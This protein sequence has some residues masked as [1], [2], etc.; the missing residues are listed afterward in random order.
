[1]GYITR[2][3]NKNATKRHASEIRSTQYLT[4]GPLVN[5]TNEFFNF[6][7]SE[8]SQTPVF[9]WKTTSTGC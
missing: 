8:N 1:M 6:I 9:C 4:N 2:V 7:D 5:A 3:K